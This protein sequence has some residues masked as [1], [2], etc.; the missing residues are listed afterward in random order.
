VACEVNPLTASGRGEVVLRD[1][2][3]GTR[4]DY[5]R[6]GEWQGRAVLVT[7]DAA[8]RGAMLTHLALEAK[9]QGAACLIYHL[10]GMREDV[11]PIWPV[12][13]ALPVLSIS[14]RDA[15]RLHRLLSEGDEMRVAFVASLEEYRSTTYNVVGTVRGSRYP[16]EVVYLTGHYDSWFL[17]AND[18][19]ATVACLLEAARALRGYRPRRTLRFV[20]WGSE[21]SGAPVGEWGLYG[22]M[23]SY[24]YGQAHRQEI[25]GV[26]E[27][28]AVAMVNGEMMGFTPRTHLQCT[29]EML[30]LGHDVAAD[31]GEHLRV[32]GPS[33]NWTLSDHLCFHA[34]GL[35]LVY[36]IPA[37][38]LG[39]GRRS[40]YW[41]VYHTQAD[42]M[43]TVSQRA[44]EENSR[45]MALLLMRLDRAAMP[46]SMDSLAHTALQGTEHLP[47]GRGLRRALAQA[48]RACRG[49]GRGEALRRCRRLAGLLNRHIYAMDRPFGLKL[50]LMAERI[51][52]LKEAAHILELEG[53]VGRA[54]SVLMSL[55][56]F[57][58]ATSFS[59]EVMS[60][61]QGVR[62]TNPVLSALALLEEDWSEVLACLEENRPLPRTVAALR[63]KVDDHQERLELWAR[64][65]EEALL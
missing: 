58:T 59:P 14:N 1:A 6:G 47:N 13:V 21:E 12:D 43:E 48:R 17:G 55:A 31:L 57:S 4:A 25:A 52:R 8:R 28:M 29:P 33:H 22:L 26:G 56:D 50:P 2:G 46:Y 37:R 38:D 20:A 23:G 54:R 9:Y 18:N 63:A 7:N 16:E 65:L 51:A 3:N 64:Q 36:L 5:A 32:S 41:H 53:D 15:A 27:E 24:G 40:P 39:S 11:I 42:N 62:R 34:L 49:G 45:L 61:V 30:L 60:K 44:L 35:P 10:P 19:A